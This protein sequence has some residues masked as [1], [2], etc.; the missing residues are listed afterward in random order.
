[1]P[2]LNWLRTFE[3]CA[4]HM[5][6]TAAANEL[7]LTQSAVSQ[8]IRGLEGRL[9]RALFLRRGRGLVLS[10]AG[11]NYLPGVQAAFG[12]IEEHTEVLTGG[13]SDQKLD[14]H[15]NLAF[16]VFWLAPRLGKLFEAHPWL[17]LNIITELH[18]TPGARGRSAVELRYGSGDWTDGAWECLVRGSFTPVAAPEVAAQISGVEDLADWR[19]FDLP[20][21]VDNWGRWLA[22]HPERPRQGAIR[23]GPLHHATTFVVAYAQAEAG[24]G[25]AMG[26][27]VLTETLIAQGRLARVFDFAAPMSDGYFLSTPPEKWS[28]AAG[29]V[30]CEWL[31]GELA[32]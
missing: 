23:T 3:V 31:Q 2:P 16:S 20:G 12:L 10:D 11:R 1:M 19:L 4:R 30:F 6:F 25:L 26:H 32:G 29:R 21:T 13:D 27:E 8:Q 14:L 18:G 15:C 22:A 7:G 17:R 24:L 5:S 9:G 28:N